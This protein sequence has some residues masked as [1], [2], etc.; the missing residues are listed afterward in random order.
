[1]NTAQKAFSAAIPTDMQEDE[2]REYIQHIYNL[3]YADGLTENLRQ[4]DQV[5]QKQFA[6]ICKAIATFYKALLLQSNIQFVKLQYCSKYNER[7][8]DILIILNDD[9]LESFFPIIN[10]KNIEIK[11]VIGPHLKCNIFIRCLP[12]IQLNEAAI[13][14]D[15]PEVA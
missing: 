3:G 13:M 6:Q 11:N 2:L 7:E 1:M 14:L 15:Y 5:N 9:N 4:W 10:A 12:A 8:V